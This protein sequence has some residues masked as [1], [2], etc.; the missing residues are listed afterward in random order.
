MPDNATTLTAFAIVGGLFAL[1]CLVAG[2]CSWL[3]D[4]GWL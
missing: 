2:V 1:I 4:R 3:D